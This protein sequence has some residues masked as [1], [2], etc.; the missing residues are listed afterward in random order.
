VRRAL[1]IAAT[2]AALALPS[3]AVAHAPVPG[4]DGFY[5]GLLHPLSTPSQVLLLLALGFFIGR[6]TTRAAAVSLAL[7]CVGTLAGVF[8][9]QRAPP[10]DTGMVV[11]ALLAASLAALAPGRLVPVGLCL[12]GLGGV[13]I[14]IVSRPDPGPLRDVIITAAGALVGTNLA[15][16]Y[17]YGALVWLQERAHHAWL[18]VALRVA[19][20]WVAAVAVLM[21]ALSLAADE[22]SPPN[23]APTVQD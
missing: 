23:T 11:V 4:V 8:L 22:P 3:V 14:G 10:P 18:P 21:L 1:L 7:F 9:G 15:M 17:L 13:G 2:L 5:T 16:V 20:A 6:G 19:A 12:A